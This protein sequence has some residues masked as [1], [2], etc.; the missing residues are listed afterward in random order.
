[1]TGVFRIF[2]SALSVGLLL[3]ASVF[4]ESDPF[5]RAGNG[6]S[7]ILFGSLGT[8]LCGI[9][10]GVTFL[11]AKVGKVSWDRFI[12]VGLCTAGF[13]GAPS[14]VTLLKTWVG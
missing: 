2:Y 12:Q 8:S 7:G 5:S 6:I 10:I 13:L 9:I 4:A 1:M 3:P 11:M 14:L